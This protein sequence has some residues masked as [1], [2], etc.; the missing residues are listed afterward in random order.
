[1]DEKRLLLGL[2]GFPLD[3]S[4]SPAWFREKFACEGRENAEYRL[5]PLDRIEKFPELLHREPCLSG[6]NVTIPYKEK[7][8]PFLDELDGTAMEVGAVNTIKITRAPGMIRSKGFNTD[9]PGFLETLAA[10][11]LKGPV[12]ILGTG[13]AA[14]AVAYA[15]RVNN[16]PYKFVS[17]GEQGAGI[18]SYN[19]LSLKVIRDHPLIVNAT[20]LGMHPSLGESPP[21]PYQFLT[22]GHVLYDLI[23]N[24]EETEFLRKG[25]MM[26]S[27]TIGGKQMLLNQAQLSYNI[28][29]RPS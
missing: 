16:I 25:K 3:H 4:W 18:I 10:P 19:D 26:N 9:A 29:N 28:F 15:L 12:L 13:G 14:K 7:I 8:I 27:G 21:I 17:R 20:P 24:P 2:I 11:K 23:Y 5:F 1:M 22:D 6:L